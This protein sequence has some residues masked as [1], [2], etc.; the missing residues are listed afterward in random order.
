MKKLHFFVLL[1]LVYSTASAQDYWKKRTSGTDKDLLSVSFG[2]STTGYIGGADSTLL[3]T[4][5]GGKT[6]TALHPTGIEF[7]KYFP[8]II[9][10]KF[11]TASK[12]YAVVSNRA[13]LDLGGAIYKT[14]DGGLSWVKQPKIYTSVYRSFFF[15]ED[16]GFITGVSPFGGPTIHELD[17]KVWSGTRYLGIGTSYLASAVTFLNKSTGIAGGDLGY[18]YLTSNGGITW[19]TVKTPSDTIINQV[20]YLNADTLLAVSSSFGNAIMISKDKGSTWSFDPHSATF[21]YPDMKDIAYSK[22]DSLII[23]GT[24]E[25]TGKGIIFFFD[26]IDPWMNIEEAEHGLNKIGMRNDTAGYIVGDSGLIL[27]NDNGDVLSVNDPASRALHQLKV[28]PNPGSGMCHTS[29]SM[30]HGLR[31]L[32]LSGRI[33]YSDETPAKEHQLQLETLP[34]AQYVLEAVW[35]NGERTSLPLQLK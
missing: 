17:H 18:V 14:T 3:K 2:S 28:Y 29:S 8:D 12:G 27:S 23:A 16:N 34:R 25:T 9:D 22:R 35:D 11:L 1:F 26:P 10:L 7:G 19:D 30:A 32:D 24:S 21:F 13:S 31:L 6:W 15:D 20:L 5:D 4:T 33:I